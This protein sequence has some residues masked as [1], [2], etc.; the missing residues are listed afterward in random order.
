[1]G[2]GDV[3]REF[4]DAARKYGLAPG[5]YVSAGDSLFGCK[6]TGDPRGKRKLIGDPE[7]YFPIFLQQLTELLTN[8]GP[9]EVIWFDGA[10]S[11]FDPDVL[12][13]SGNPVGR[14]Y[15]DRID[16]VVW[17]LQPDAVIMGGGNSDI[18]WSGSEQGKAPYP[19]WNIVPPGKGMENWLPDYAEGWFVPE[20]NI[21]TRQH[22][23]W[24][25]DTDKTLKSPMQMMEAYDS[26]IGLGAN[27]LVNM[28][29]DTDGLIPTAEAGMLTTF[30]AALKKRFS[31]M[32]GTVSSKDDWTEEKPLVL[33][34]DHPTAVTDVVIE[35][36]LR[37]GQRIQAYSIE[38]FINGSWSPFGKG[39]SI[40]RKRIHTFKPI[41]AEA[42]R[43]TILQ[44]T[45]VPHIRAF[46]AY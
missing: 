45:S 29:P 10:Y 38:Y 8:Y 28:T 16:E 37:Q 9:L 15:V 22:W 34:F 26:S 7:A 5:L 43:L 25:P 33:K 27:L 36:D 19:L 3:V 41:E 2:K 23:F 46:S 30:G 42:L 14:Q 18:R 31:D 12:D 21:H 32:K 6:S 24:S 44:S 40:G 4:V 35:E 1:D 20:S 39:S 17:R 13:A 11:P